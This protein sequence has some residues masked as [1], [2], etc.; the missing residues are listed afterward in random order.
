MHAVRYTAISPFKT[1]SNV[2]RHDRIWV[3]DRIDVNGPVKKSDLSPTSE[4]AYPICSV[5]IE[6]VK[7]IDD[8]PQTQG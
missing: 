7:K 6:L 3:I 5:N 2:N 8:L 4:L 1:R